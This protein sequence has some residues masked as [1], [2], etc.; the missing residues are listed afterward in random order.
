MLTKPSF[1]DRPPLGSKAA[2][3]LPARAVASPVF[4]RALSG[5]L[6]IAAAAMF[7]TEAVSW[8]V[9]CC[10]IAASGVLSFIGVWK[11]PYPRRMNGGWIGYDDGGGE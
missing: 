7:M 11:D 3:S 10:L 6:F 9:F 4:W 5:A 8:V 1:D 2:R